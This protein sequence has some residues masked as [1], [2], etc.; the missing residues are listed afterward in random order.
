MAVLLKYLQ[1][2]LFIPLLALAGQGVLHVLAGERRE[3]NVFYRL[4]RW[5]SW[6]LAAP[7][8]RALPAALSPAGAGWAVFGIVAGAYAAV[9]LSRIAWCLHIGV[10]ACR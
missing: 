5:L 7:L 8:R 6:P 10:A 2:L 4:L 9:T 1:L 3:S